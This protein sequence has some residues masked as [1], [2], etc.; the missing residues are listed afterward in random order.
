MRW[1]CSVR[2]CESFFSELKLSRCGIAQNGFRITHKKMRSRG[3]FILPKTH[4][5]KPMGASAFSI[6]PQNLLSD[7][8]QMRTIVARQVPAH[9][10]R[11]LPVMFVALHHMG[12]FHSV[13][14]VASKPY[15][16]VY[17]SIRNIGIAIYREK[18]HHVYRRDTYRRE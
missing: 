18:N 17:L 5:N 9:S 14:P 16:C 11:Q 6:A 13:M 8:K 10:E 1:Y 2:H 4:L 7:K 12:G 3:F 15:L